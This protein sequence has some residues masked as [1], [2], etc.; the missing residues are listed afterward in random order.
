VS[1]LLTIS[2]ALTGRSIAELE[3]A[4]SGKGYGDLKGDLAEVVVGVA[5]PYRERTLALLDDT[6]SLDAL[7]AEGADRARSIAAGTLA[8]VYE[9]VGFLAGSTDP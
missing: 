7:L 9:R 2:S 8:R 1:N 4:Y 3:D 5:A 6:E